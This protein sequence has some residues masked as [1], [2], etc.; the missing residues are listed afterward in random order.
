MKHDLRGKLSCGT[1]W[2]KRLCG[3][4]LCREFPPPVHISMNDYITSTI[5][6]IED[7]GAHRL[8]TDVR[9][10]ELEPDGRRTVGYFSFCALG[11]R[12]NIESNKHLKFLMIFSIFDA[13]VDSFYSLPEGLTF[14]LKYQSIQENSNL[15]TC[16]KH[17]YRLAKIVRNSLVHNPSKIDF[18]N[19]INI[20][21]SYKN[22]PV[23]LNIS[24]YGC[25]LF[26]EMILRVVS[27]KVKSTRGEAY[28]TAMHNDLIKEVTN[29]KDEFNDSL[30]PL[31]G[32]ELNWRVRN[33]IKNPDVV[34]DD[35]WVHMKTIP[36]HDDYTL[37]YRIEIK[38]VKCEVPAEVLDGNQKVTVKE[39]LRWACI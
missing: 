30:A 39:A 29:L 21:Y 24:E 35:D 7:L 33:L 17:L 31:S 6:A 11:T 27:R 1:A 19:G 8:I 36:R 22:S 10:I 25:Q 20:S 12:T 5:T 23:I 9:H 4:K 15:D 14:K 28:L 13:Y 3:R 38:G 34:I 32:L 26:D 37:D 16:T 18:T 2:G